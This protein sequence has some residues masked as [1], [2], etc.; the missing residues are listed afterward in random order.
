MSPL[1]AQFLTAFFCTLVVILA[2]APFA[3]RL[4]LVDTPTE[5]KQ[6]AE[7]VPL[8]GGIA[9][10]VTFCVGIL[11]WGDA[12]GASLIIRDENA[13]SVLMSCCAF[14]V[15]TGALDD[16]YNLGVFLR[17]ASEVLVALIII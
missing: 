12:W 16:R 15:V 2:F 8:I 6:H 17:I 9:I 5:R 11:I 1:L 4:K 10:F 13:L 3:V 7:K 14:L